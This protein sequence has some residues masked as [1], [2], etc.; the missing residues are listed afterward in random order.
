MWKIRGDKRH[1][2]KTIILATDCCVKIVV[3]IS[4]ARIKAKAL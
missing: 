4:V 2:L 1:I 3:V